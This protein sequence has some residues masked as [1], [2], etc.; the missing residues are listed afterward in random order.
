MK[1]IFLLLAF[2]GTVIFSSGQY[3]DMGP[4]DNYLSPENPYYWKKKLPFEGYWQ[5]DV[6]YKIRAALDSL[7][8]NGQ[9][10]R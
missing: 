8:D 5:Q 3:S 1:N 7:K 4:N 6:Q 10:A 9:P 2:W